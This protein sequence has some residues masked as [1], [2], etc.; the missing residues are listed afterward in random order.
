MVVIVLIV[1]LIIFYIFNYILSNIKYFRLP[2]PGLC[3]PVI[4]HA[5]KLIFQTLKNNHQRCLQELYKMNQNGGLLFL[6]LLN[7]NLVVV[8]DLETL[9]HIFNHSECQ[10]RMSLEINQVLREER[11]MKS[12]D[13]Q[14]VVF[15]SGKIWSEQR[16]LASRVLKDLCCGEPGRWNI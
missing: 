6:R 14:G 16:K 1:I 8:G 2:S 10:D 4:G 11:R 7:L 9:K 15:S 13:F 5:H 12:K 3:F